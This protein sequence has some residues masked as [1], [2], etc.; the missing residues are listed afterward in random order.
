MKGCDVA[1]AKAMWSPL[2]L[3][4]PALRGPTSLPLVPY[5][6]AVD[7]LP[8]ATPG[9]NDFE[10]L[11]WRI[12]RDVE[13]LRMPL[14]YGTP[15][16]AQFGLDVV[17]TAPDDSRVAIQSKQEKQFGPAK[18]EAAVKAFT[19]QKQPAPVSKL[20]LAVSRP[21]RTTAAADKAKAMAKSLLPIEFVI[22][23]QQ[24]LS[25][26]LKSHPRI[27][28]DYFGMSV[29]KHFCY[30]FEVDPI[31][32]PNENAVA[33]RE[34]L[35]RTP[36]VVTG[37]DAMIAEAERLGVKEPAQALAQVEMA[38]G[39]LMSAGFAG[40]ASRHEA[41]RSPL[42]VQ[43]NRGP[44]ATRR[45]LDE[46]WESLDQ[47][48]VINADIARNDIDSLV[49]RAPSTESEEH[50]AIAGAAVGLYSNPLAHV[51]DLADL[52]VGSISD[53]ARLAVLAGETALASD[54]QNW[55]TTHA[56]ALNELSAQLAGDNPSLS[57]RLRLLA[58][59]GSSSWGS[60]LN[61]ARK[62]KLGDHLGALVKARYARHQ[63][64]QQLFQEADA[65]W[66]EAAGDACLAQAWSDA[67]RWIVSR[68]AFLG[69]WKPFTSNELLPIQSAMAARGPTRS[70]LNVDDDALETAYGQFADKKY[71]SAA[72]SAQRALRDAITLSDW[73]AERR[74]RRL[75]ADILEASGEPNLAARH[76]VRAGD[77][78][79]LKRLAENNPD[80]YLDVTDLLAS[81]PYWIVGAAYRMI[82]AQAD[83]VPDDAVEAIT[84]SILGE[85]ASV[86]SGTLVDL[87]TF[88][89]SRFRGSLAALAGLASRLTRKQAETALAYFEAQPEVEPGH[90]RLHD[91]DEASTAAGILATHPDLAERA[92]AHLISLLVRSDTSRT[93]T[94]VEAV[95]SH[96]T[97]A[98]SLLEAHDEAGSTWA[99]DVLAGEGG[100]SIDEKDAQKALTRLTTP[101][102]HA[103]GVYSSG[104]GRGS[105][106]DS[107]LIKGLPGADLNRAMTELL[108]RAD[109]PRHSNSDRSYYLLSASN[110]APHL[111]KEDRATHLETALRLATEPTTSFQEAVEQ[112]HSHQLGFMRMSVSK[113]SRAQAAHLAACLAATAS[114]RERVRDVTMGLVGDETV[115]E[116]WVTE[117]LKR[118]GDLM[119]SDVGF[120]S[121]QGWALRSFAASLWTKSAQPAPIGYLLAN[122]PDVRVRRAL[123]SSLSMVEIKSTPDESTDARE[124]VLKIL[125]NDPRFSVRRA[126]ERC[127]MSI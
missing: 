55:L 50:R 12:L 28:I 90:H 9:W 75:L 120:L 68:R 74:A 73:A 65:G 8:F 118:L 125:R 45:R 16:Q 51:P 38:Q 47:G 72:I 79:G 116:T 4:S 104:G 7:L 26:M 81:T 109:D 13:G 98:R 53:R 80:R 25:L 41:L 58:A 24:E 92:M 34:A 37:A 60:V 123:A 100:S 127:P 59:E 107:I 57:V 20:I 66:D 2:G 1:K 21:V 48:L 97:Q 105:L 43:L 84:E 22:W 121:G 83:L 93:P 89:T 85:L 19:K 110:I 78:T 112:A 33:I 101:S 117:A 14:M 94:A 69:R 114:E 119:T 111:T 70:V 36:E 96:L 103:D 52:D 46:L 56:D 62:T 87:T 64:L 44:E 31:V 71:R 17:A 15:G 102:R 77:V 82:A 88:D 39:A 113:G 115:A 40:H 126:T 76:L 99:R 5:K 18:I 122:D 42:L 54:N 6:D 30:D 67:V 49:A 10:S 35:A 86:A 108:V 27:V 95:T 3:D 106:S 11:L 32:V 23:D 91:E 124:T 63:A 61:D 29:A